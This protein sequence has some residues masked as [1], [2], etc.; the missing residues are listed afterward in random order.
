MKR[1]SNLAICIVVI[2]LTVSAGAANAD[3]HHF[4]GRVE[5]A[6]SVSIHYFTEGAGLPTLVFVHCWSCDGSYWQDQIDFFAK[7]HRVV[8]I[9]LGGHGESGLDR[10]EWTMAAYGADVAAVL[11]EQ[12]LEQVILIGHSMGGAVVAEAA[13]LEPERVIGL[14]GIDNFQNVDMKLTEAQI[15]GFEGAFKA[16]FKAT[17]NGWVRSMFPAGSDE[18]LVTAIAED[19]SS[20]PPKVA[21]SSLVQLLHWYGGEAPARLELLQAPLMC[22]NSDGEPTNTEA[23]KKVVPGYQ[24]RLMPGRGHFLMREDPVTFNALLAETIAEFE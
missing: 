21:I 16:D 18:E 4:T 6:D 2:G 10:S 5:S 15:T 7:D 1:M 17:A 24:L 20:A 9:D 8:V 12:D 11:R 23:I 22:I 3:T 19:M 14:V 13:I